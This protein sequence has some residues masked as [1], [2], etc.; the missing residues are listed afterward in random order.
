VRRDAL[1]T[2]GNWRSYGS[3]E[4][5]GV[6][7]GQRAHSLRE[8]VELP[9]RTTERFELALAIHPDEHRDLEALSGNGWH[10][11]DPAQVAGT[12]SAYREFVQRSKGELGVAKSGYVR[13]R[14]GWFSDRS[15]CYLA[16]GRPVV[17]Q[18]TGFSDFVP[19]GEGLLAFENVDDAASAVE[20]LRHDYAR[21]ARAAREFAEEHL[22]SDVVLGRLLERVD[23]V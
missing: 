6:H 16:S 2:V 3:I 1:T 7:Y 22:D 12:P 23:A 15:C 10:L 17:A 14:C 13:S 8:V 20:A 18:E 19:T 5:D 21:H 11:V 9:R 4:R